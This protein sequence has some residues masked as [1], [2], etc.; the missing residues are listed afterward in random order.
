MLL[1]LGIRKGNLQTEKN[2]GRV[3]IDIA[4]QIGV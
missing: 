1:S 3:V 4:Y 2:I